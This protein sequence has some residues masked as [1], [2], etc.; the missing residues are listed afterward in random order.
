M[1]VA[2][3]RHGVER[4]WYSWVLRAG[5]TSHEGAVTTGCPRVSRT[6]QPYY[7]PLVTNEG[8]GRVPTDPYRDREGAGTKNQ[9]LM[10]SS[11]TRTESS[12]AGSKRTL[13]RTTPSTIIR[14]GES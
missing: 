13:V 14:S 1:R 11:I 7:P 4:R 8:V 6:W 5:G 10:S 3:C 2:S 9:A 12:S